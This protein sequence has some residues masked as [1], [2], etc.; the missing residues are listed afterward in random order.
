MSGRGGGDEDCFFIFAWWS[1]VELVCTI[2]LRSEMLS[3]FY[4]MGIKVTCCLQAWTKRAPA[5]RFYLHC[6]T[7]L[8]TKHCNMLNIFLEDFQLQWVFLFLIHSPAIFFSFLV[9]IM[10]CSIAFALCQMHTPWWFICFRR[11]LRTKETWCCSSAQNVCV[12]C[13]TPDGSK[14]NPVWSYSF[15]SHQSCFHMSS[16]LLLLFPHGNRKRP[17]VAPVSAKILFTIPIHLNLC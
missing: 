12:F 16:S 6:T 10:L 8:N 13:P 11:F 14:I 7:P 9:C 15:A 1:Q 5:L 2:H 4:D 3:N 17:L